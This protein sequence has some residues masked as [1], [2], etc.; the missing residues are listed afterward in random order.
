MRI[1]SLTKR[2]DLKIEDIIVINDLEINLA[3]HKIF[4]EDKEIE[5]SNKEYLIIEYLAKN[6]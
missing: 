3:K 5:L 2:K 6:R 4:K 1:R